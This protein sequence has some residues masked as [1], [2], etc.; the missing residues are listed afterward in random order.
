MIRALGGILFLIG[1]LI[2]VYNLWQ[3][4]KG[5]LRNER[6]FGEAQA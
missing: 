1:S 6:P 3:T 4:A 2:M 5:K